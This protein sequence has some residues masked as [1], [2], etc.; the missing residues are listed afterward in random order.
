[1]AIWLSMTF[2]AR[3]FGNPEHARKTMLAAS[4][5]YGMAAK[6]N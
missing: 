6:E 4:W 1:M 3:R 5:F 2:L